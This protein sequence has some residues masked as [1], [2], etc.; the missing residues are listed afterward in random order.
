MKPDS[1][2]HSSP[3]CTRVWARRIAVVFASPVSSTMSRIVI[4]G[5]SSLSRFR[6]SSARWTLRTPPGSVDLR[7]PRGGR[8]PGL[9]L[10]MEPTPAVDHADAWIAVVSVR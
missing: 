4:C 8:V 10:A 6:I 1:V 5:R 3:A 2:A 7:V 9:P